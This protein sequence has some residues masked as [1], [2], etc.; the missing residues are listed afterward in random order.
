MSNA[1]YEE[2]RSEGARQI[3]KVAEKLATE[4]GI[5]IE[6]AEWDG[7][8]LIAEKDNH[9]LSITANGKTISGQFPDEWL[10]DYPGRA[11][12]EKAN[13]VLSEIIRKLKK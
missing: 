5:K 3:I 4:A 1:R 11:G 12:N 6:R 10:A 9:S 2:Q 8:K 13:A 7:G